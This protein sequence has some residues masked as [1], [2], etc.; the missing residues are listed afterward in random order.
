MLPDT[1]SNNKMTRGPEGCAVILAAR[2]RLAF[3]FLLKSL[4]RTHRILSIL[5]K[6][7]SA[8]A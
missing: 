4:N 7:I 3:L 6:L 8:S 2:R 1:P 5:L